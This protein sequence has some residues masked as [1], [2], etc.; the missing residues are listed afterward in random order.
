MN[1]TQSYVSL[2]FLTWF[3]SARFKGI[4][5]RTQILSF[6]ISAVFSILEVYIYLNSVLLVFL[7][8]FFVFCFCFC[9]LSPRGQAWVVDFRNQSL[10]RLLSQ[11]NRLCFKNCATKTL[12][13]H[14]QVRDIFLDPRLKLCWPWSVFLMDNVQPGTHAWSVFTPGFLMLKEKK[15]KKIFKKSHGY[16][17]SCT[18]AI[19]SSKIKLCT[20]FGP[21]S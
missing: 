16:L 9:F 8:S 18:V 17:V 12:W 19:F 3:L 13:E 14:F 4:S 1:I 6:L 7:F 21:D 20:N 5:L 2:F 11:N 10:A 15:M